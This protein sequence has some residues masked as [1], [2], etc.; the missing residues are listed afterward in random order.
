MSSQG[1]CL[2]YHFSSQNNN[3]SKLAAG[4]HIYNPNTLE[5]EAR[6]TTAGSK[7]LWAMLWVLN[8]SGLYRRSGLKYTKH[9]KPKKT[10]QI[11]RGAK[12]SQLQNKSE[13]DNLTTRH[14]K[15]GAIGFARRPAQTRVELRLVT[16]CS[17]VKGQGSRRPIVTLANL[18][19]QWARML[20]SGHSNFRMISKL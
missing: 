7:P 11:L 4:V 10:P 6:S 20:G 3:I 18:L 13:T 12:L 16:V 17:D 2:K 8:Q 15:G 1:S 9:P 19:M 5:A 14:G